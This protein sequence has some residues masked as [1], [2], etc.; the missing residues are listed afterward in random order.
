MAGQ[1]T[2]MRPVVGAPKL[3]TCSLGA[4][5]SSRLRQRRLVSH[6]A[7]RTMAR[8]TLGRCTMRRAGTRTCACVQAEHREERGRLLG[9]RPMLPRSRGPTRRA[10]RRGCA[11]AHVP[12]AVRS[13]VQPEPCGIIA[14]LTV[15]SGIIQ[16][17]GRATSVPRPR[18]PRPDTS[19]GSAR[20]A[21][22][23]PWR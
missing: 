19:L 8:P 18:E 16:T 11:D 5:H 23:R 12:R 6:S 22:V 21:K 10:S 9:V 1:S 4:S 13:R 2:H 14:C 7:R 20:P 3:D 15:T 17:I